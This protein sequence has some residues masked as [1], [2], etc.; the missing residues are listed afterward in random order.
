M[1]AALTI[2]AFHDPDAPVRGP[3]AGP[4]HAPESVPGSLPGER[5]RALE[6][7]LRARRLQPDAPPLRGEDHRQRPVS[8]GVAAIDALA[9]GGLPR[10]QLSEVHGPASSGRTGF[11]VA[12][13]ASLTSA[14]G[15]AA[16]VDPLD[17]FDPGSAAAA[18]VE[19]S[20]LLW[21]RGPRL[22][23]E[24]PAPKALD[25]AA[26]AV[27]TLAGSGL[28]DLVA[29][30][31]A[32]ATGAAKRL[33]PATT[34]LRLARVVEETKTALVV[35]ADGHLASSP[36]GVCV[37]LEPAGPSWSAPPGPG[38]RLAAILTRAR[39]GRHGR[40]M[41]DLAFAAPA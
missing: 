13:I 20:R 22:D 14:G 12:A 25:G 9:G 10:G 35:L 4:A 40:R 39:A 30:D 41:A 3:A 24:E 26:A 21:L 15:L 18:G 16:L 17:R 28:F 33:L 8:T 19:L 32:G 31:L 27:S 5:K 34:W 7:L 11:L 23:R 2:P 37:A 29:L 6:A 36:G 1:S 38:R